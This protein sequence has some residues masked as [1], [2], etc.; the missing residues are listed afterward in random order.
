MAKSK[1][2]EK[3]ENL[4]IVQKTIATTKKLVLP[5]FEG[6]SLYQVL[7]FFIQGLQ[8]GYVM[9]RASAISYQIILALAP[10]LI[11]LLTLIPYIP[12]DNFQDSLMLA[13]EGMLP[14][15][16][17][18]FV[19]NTLNDL[20]KAKHNTFLS[21]SFLLGIYYASNSVNALLQGFRG[22]YNLVNKTNIFKQRAYSIL[23]VV[24]LPLFIGSGFLVQTFTST[25][26]DYLV[27]KELMF[28]GVQTILVSIAKWITVLLLF[29]AGI[30][31]LYNL[32][33]P[34]RTKWRF[35]SA[36]SSFSALMIIIISQL[37]T[38]YVNNFGQFN[39]FYG[40]LA[41]VVILLI[42]IQF[43]NVILLLGFE[44][45]TSISRAQIKHKEQLAKLDEEAFEN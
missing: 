45:N 43:I 31:T 35:I 23:L 44:L 8:K 34:D 24:V 20:I 11:L 27:E 25:V 17:F 13:I 42:Y 1:L 15:S 30:S 14:E 32:G 22:S 9:A 38:W 40:S 28:D 6:L 18:D 37:F 26:V 5:G 29:L 7:F 21:I 19:E 3:L 36:G 41:T 12:V 2:I 33:N 10:T 4:A 39:K 16:T